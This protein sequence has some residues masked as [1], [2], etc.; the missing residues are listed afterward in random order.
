M[1]LIIG[2]ASA[3][4]IYHIPVNVQ[5]STEP[6][7]LMPGD[8]A[9]LSIE[10][11]NGAAQYGA[12]SETL[13]GTLST[14]INGTTLR[15]TNE[16]AVISPDYKDI[17]MIGPTDKVTLYYKIKAANTI[18]YAHGTYF[19]DFGVSGGYEMVQINREIPVTVDSSAVSIARADVPT[20]PSINLNV[21]NPR[22]NTV[23]AVTI[24]PSAQGIRFSPDQYYIGTMDSDEVFTISFG[25]DSDN[26]AKPINR[27]V[28]LSF[29]AKFK[30]GDT[31]HE[32]VEYITS[33]MPPKDNSRQNSYLLPAG[34]GALIL[35]GAGI[36]L[37]RRKKMA[38]K[39]V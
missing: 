33:Y 13:T 1:I 6:A 9:I 28:N 29:V 24:V 36:F 8:T 19:M 30:N 3:S 17:G 37:Y 14:P 4:Y 34:V 21:A 20:K 26:P 23:N 18:S 35:L 31:W 7:V 22:A 2:P 5:S 38:S 15:G 25:I 39:P 12:G 11:Q 10:L 27:P 16:I 32:S